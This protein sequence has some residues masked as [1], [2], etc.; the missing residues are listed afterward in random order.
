MRGP[1]SPCSAASARGAAPARGAAIRRSAISTAGRR[2]TASA[3]MRT[4]CRRTGPSA[5]ALL[6][7]GRCRHAVQRDA[8]AGVPLDRRVPLRHAHPLLVHPAAV[9]RDERLRLAARTAARNRHPQ[10]A[11]GPDA[12]DVLAG[13]PD[14]NE[15]DARLRRGRSDAQE[16]EIQ[17]HPMR[18]RQ[19]EL[20]VAVRGFAEFAGS[21][22]EV[23][24]LRG[25]RLLVAHGDQRIDGHRTA[26]G[27]VAGH[28]RD[29]Q[30]EDRHQRRS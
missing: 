16:W 3:G 21:G 20:Q 1:V 11:V 15:L 10:R 24:E 9:P 14:A 7:G 2:L 25:D 13:A 23:G 5:A 6:L 12:K 30:Q 4:R 27:D 18:I 29:A 28:Q 26:R 8:I 17:L 22:V 19:G